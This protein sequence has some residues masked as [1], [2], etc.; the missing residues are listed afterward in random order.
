[1]TP[2]F[3][4]KASGERELW[5]S[6]KL[7]RS[8]RAAKASG[9]LAKEVVKHV[10]KDLRDGLRTSDIYAHAFSLLKQYDRPSAAQ[11]SLRRAINELGPSGFPFERFV[12][13]ILRAEGYRTHVGTIIPGFCVSHEVDVIAEK[14]DERILVEAK[15]H[16]SSGIKSD[17]KVALYV[18]ARFAD[19]EKRFTREESHERFTHAWLITN[20]S[21]TSQAIQYGTCAGLALTGWNYPK[22]RTL[23]DLVQE[24]RTHPVTCLTTLSPAHK[25]QLLNEGVVLCQDVVKDPTSLSRIG[26]GKA[27]AA[28]VL[29]EGSQLCPIVL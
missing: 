17:V 1:M 13:E 29:K 28:S 2:I 19:I 26:I 10:E 9:D 24:T 12:S 25:T 15:F 4:V 3:I 6:Q 21:F 5:D 7:E 23:Q 8:L 22:G 27:R 11:Y 18:A 20:T 16:N 14:Q